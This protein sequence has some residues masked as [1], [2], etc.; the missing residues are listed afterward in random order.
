MDNFVSRHVHSLG[1]LNMYR[2]YPPYQPTDV[3]LIVEVVR[4]QPL[5]LVVRD[6]SNA[7]LEVNH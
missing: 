3:L 5:D 2:D 6:C 1:H 4:I 7:N